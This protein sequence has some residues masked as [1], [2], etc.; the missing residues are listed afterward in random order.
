MPCRKMFPPRL[1]GTIVSMD[2][3]PV[4]EEPALCRHGRRPDPGHGR[5]R[6]K[7]GARPT[8]F[9]GIPENTYVSDL[10]ASRFDENIVFAIFDNILRDDFKPY[11]LKSTDK[12]KTWD[13]HRREPSGKRDRPQHSSRT[14]SIPTCSSQGPNSGI[15]HPR[16]RKELDP[17]EIGASRPFPSRISPSRNGKT[18][19]SWPLSDAGFYILDDYSPLRYLT[20]ENL[21]RDG[22]LFPVK[23]AL[24]YLQTDSKYGQGST[25]YAAKNPDFGAMFT[26]YRER[27][28]EDKKGDPQ[29]EGERSSSKKGNRSPSRPMPNCGPRSPRSSRI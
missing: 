23:D 29:G 11:L 16:R 6:E 7:P 27:C 9:P 10:H 21:D 4:K 20:K 13:I 15:L 22:Y 19:W 5:C 28:S 12:G 3:S 18:T 25:V 24:M 2:E 14:T 26:Y 1:Y 17:A 8:N